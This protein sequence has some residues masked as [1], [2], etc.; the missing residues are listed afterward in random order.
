VLALEFA[1]LYGL[2]LA[3]AR[4]PFRVNPIPLLWLAT[5]Y[6]LCVLRADSRFDR[7]RLGNYAA[8]AENW[9]GMVKLFCAVALALLLLVWLLARPSLFGLVRAYP[10]LWAIVMVLYP[11]LSVYPQGIVYRVFLFHRYQ[12]LLHGDRI[13][14]LASAATFSLAHVLLH[15]RLAVACTFLGGL[16]FA[17]RYRK[18]KSLLASAFEHALYGCWMF[19]VG[20]GR[21]F[22]HAAR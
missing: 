9:G 5:L 22:Y 4:L 6:C 12:R 7:G 19:T 11:V 13:L 20:L 18:T 8:L 10:W 17:W 1:A 15:N 2:P 21:Y 3:V 16:L 14:L